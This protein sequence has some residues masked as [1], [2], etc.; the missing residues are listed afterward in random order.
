MI[1]TSGIFESCESLTNSYGTW[2]CSYGTMSTGSETS[3][4]YI[5]NTIGTSSNDFTYKDSPSENVLDFTSVPILSFDVRCN[6]SL[7]SEFDIVTKTGETEW[8]S[9]STPMPNSLVAGEWVSQTVDLREMING[10]TLEPA[11]LT[12]ILRI[13]IYVE[14]EYEPAI[15]DISNIETNNGE[16]VSSYKSY[17]TTGSNELPQLCLENGITSSSRY[18]CR[19][20]TY[21]GPCPFCGSSIQ[22]VLDFNSL[23]G[24]WYGRCPMC[25]KVWRHLSTDGSLSDFKEVVIPVNNTLIVDLSDGF[26]N[27]GWL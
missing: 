22:I 2:G 14:N 23:V 8:E 21:G 16:V 12:K 20:Y 18:G 27:N 7:V 10:V 9:A 6:R 19:T 25:N 13:V 15:L 4:H 11:D 17:Q 24:D 5:R 1:V 3:R 26:E